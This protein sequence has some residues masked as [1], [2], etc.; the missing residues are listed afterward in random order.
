MAP[1]GT[2]LGKL[3]EKLEQATQ[4]KVPEVYLERLEEA[5]KLPLPRG[6]AVPAPRPDVW[7]SRGYLAQYRYATQYKPLLMHGRVT[8]GIVYQYESSADPDGCDTTA[9]YAWFERPGE[10]RDARLRESYDG[11]HAALGRDKALDTKVLLV[12]MEAHLRLGRVVTIV[13][14]ESQHVIFEALRTDFGNE[15]GPSPADDM[16]QL[17]DGYLLK[18]E[19]DQE[20]LRLHFGPEPVMAA[21]P[22]TPVGQLRPDASEPGVWWLSRM[23]PRPERPW[24]HSVPVKGARGVTAWRM[25]GEEGEEVGHAKLRGEHLVVTHRGTSVRLSVDGQGGWT[26]ENDKGQPRLSCTRVPKADCLRLAL[27]GDF[28][29]SLEVLLLALASAGKPWFPV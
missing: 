10:L 27:Q 8:R 7:L 19:A 3:L 28:R 9:R 25:L 23:E 20:G 15:L 24:L 4:V 21:V 12:D 18:W 17:F 6:L 29:V 11:L 22:Y 13:H 2:F 26:A 1:I 5:L 16:E 14:D